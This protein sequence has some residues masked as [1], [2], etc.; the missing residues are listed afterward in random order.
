MAATVLGTALLQQT[1]SAEALQNGVSA[2]DFKLLDEETGNTIT[3]QTF[4]GK[5][6]FIFFTTTW[7]TPCQIG[8]ENLAKYD[9]ETGGSAFNVLIV[10]VD[11]KETEKQFIDWKK[12][13]GRGDWYVAKGIDMA[14]TYNVQYLDTKY[15]F[16]GNGIIKWI[17]IKPLEYSNIKPILGS[18]L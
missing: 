13:H 10:F 3:K 17:D 9:D 15:I 12:D 4:N 2:P 5:P 1:V 6:L 11:D 16:D 14:Q 8:A 18:L 7:C